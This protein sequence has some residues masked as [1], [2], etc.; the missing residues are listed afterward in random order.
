MRLWHERGIFT[1]EEGAERGIRTSTSLGIFF[2]L[3]VLVLVV[4]VL[5]CKGG[6]DYS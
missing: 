4:P 2:V 6:L 5:P 3:N 1:E